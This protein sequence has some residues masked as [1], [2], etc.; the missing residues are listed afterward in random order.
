FHHSGD[1]AKGKDIVYNAKTRRVSVC[2]ALDCL[3]IDKSRL[4]DLAALT[5]DLQNKNVTIFADEPA[6][7]ALEGRYAPSLL[8]HANPEHF[9][10]E[11]LDYKMSIR[12]VSDFEEALD[13]INTYSSRHS[14]AIIAEDESVINLFLRSV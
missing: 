1:I 11:F 3:I 13:H 8:K 12:T 14:E 4:A 6:F 7:A 9:G 2:N 5:E 10:T